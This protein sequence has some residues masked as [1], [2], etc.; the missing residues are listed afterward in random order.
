MDDPISVLLADD[1]ALVRDMLRHRLI[2]EGM[3]VVGAAAT[4]DEATQLGIA[5]HPDV[6]VLDIDLPGRSAFDAARSIQQASP[7]TRVVF[8]SA[9]VHDHYIEQA[10]EVEASGY[11]TKAEPPDAVVRGIQTVVRGAT[12]FSQEVIERVVIEESGARLAGGHARIETLTD[13]ERQ[14]LA[15]VARGLQQKQIARLAGISLKTVQHHV[16]HVMDKLGIHDRV[17]LARFAI[18]EGIVEA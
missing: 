14:V 5:L 4:A 11:L 15:Y 18:R 6:A 10:L 1:H 8:L 9:F 2:E 13:R 3:T 17:E 16:T 12:C 7:S